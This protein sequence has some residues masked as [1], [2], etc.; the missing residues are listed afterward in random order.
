MTLVPA[1]FD[2]DK[3]VKKMSSNA[4][5]ALVVA[6]LILNIGTFG[7]ATMALWD[8]APNETKT[9][10]YRKGQQFSVLV[11]NE[12][13]IAVLPKWQKGDP[14]NNLATIYQFKKS[15]YESIKPKIKQVTIHENLDVSGK[16][17][18]IRCCEGDFKIALDD[19]SQIILKYANATLTKRSE[20]EVQFDDPKIDFQRIV[21]GEK[22][23]DFSWLWKIPLTPV[24]VAVDVPLTGLLLIIGLTGK[25]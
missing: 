5:R 7:C 18:E 14:L 6:L 21:F 1:C 2:K 15:T 20:H 24:A 13:Q 25:M 10:S 16:Q 4:S 11:L 3:P 23:T 22:G 19:D 9:L 8:K 17:K 12:D